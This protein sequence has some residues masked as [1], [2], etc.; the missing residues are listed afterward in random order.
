[1]TQTPEAG[2]P[3]KLRKGHCMNWF[4]STFVAAIAAN[5]WTTP[6]RATPQ[7][8][9]AAYARDFADKGTADQW[10]VRNENALKDCLLIALPATTAEPKKITKPKIVETKK[11]KQPSK[12][13][14]KPAGIE[15]PKQSKPILQV[16][17]EAWLNYCD[18]KYASFDRTK[19]TYESF[20]G[21]ER[22]CLVTAE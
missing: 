2:A 5:V 4:R 3:C 11:S 15:K 22:K 9:C 13:V 16:G 20:S 8:Y 1:M 7:D 14:A 17:S 19:G 21:V 12:S 6:V 18:K 10:Q